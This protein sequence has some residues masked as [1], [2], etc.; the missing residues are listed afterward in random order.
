M[1]M[2]VF[3]YVYVSMCLCVD[4]TMCNTISYHSDNQYLVRAKGSSYFCSMNLDLSFMHL[5]RSLK[6]HS[7]F[8]LSLLFVS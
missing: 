8:L 5:F 1:C 3:L 4:I 6:V 7:F 2:Y